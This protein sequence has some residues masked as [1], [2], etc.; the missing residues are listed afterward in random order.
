MN[1]KAYL[2]RKFSHIKER[3]LNPNHHDYPYYG[4]RGINIDEEWLSSPISF[5]KWAL[6]HG[7]KKGLTI[8]RIDNNGDYSPE[9]CRWTTR[10][11]QNQ[12][13]RNKV[14][15]LIKGTRICTICGIKKPLE[16]FYPN[17]SQSAGRGYVC[18]ACINKNLYK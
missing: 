5:I 2:L 17:P 14:T 10:Q 9:N 16:K 6:A 8:D 11:E 3:C 15:D 1:T 13:K 18:K 4:G 12:N 7:W